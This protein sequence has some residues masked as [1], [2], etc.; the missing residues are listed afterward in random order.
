MP[1]IVAKKFVELERNPLKWKGNLIQEEK[2][3]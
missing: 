2:K 1:K 3:L